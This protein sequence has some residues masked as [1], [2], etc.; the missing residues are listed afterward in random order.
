MSAV[1][2]TANDLIIGALSNINVREA[3]EPVSAN[4]AADAL[5]TLNDLID[6]LSTDKLFVYTAQESIVSWIP[7]QFKYTVGNPIGGTFSGTITSGSAVITGVTV[8]SNIVAG[9]SLSDF[10]AGIPAGTTVLSFNTGAGTVTMTAN[11][12]ATGGDTVTY[13]TPGNINIARPLRIRQG[14]TRITSSGNTG[15]DYWFDVV[16]IDDYNEIGYKGVSGPWPILVSY[17]T[18]FPLG[19]LFVYPNP[20]QGGEVHLWTD[21]VLS[22]F[23]TLT[24]T[25]ILPQGYA[26]ALK[27]L[28]AIELA[29]AYGKNPSPELMRQAKESRDYIKAMNEVPVKRLRYDSAITR[30]NGKDAGWAQHGGFL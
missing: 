17:Q 5:Q 26:R 20:S 19:T 15:L 16:S 24:Q 1:T 29:P 6:S 18:T 10:L 11:A 27:K 21:V 23:L 12:T 7:N 22:Q 9:G 28:L 4:D 30:Q 14:F 2:S 3:S 25:I 8:P 13:T